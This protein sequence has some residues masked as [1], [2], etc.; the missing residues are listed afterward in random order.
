[1]KTGKHFEQTI[2]RRL[3]KEKDLLL[4]LSTGI[5]ISFIA[6]FLLNY[7]TISLASESKTMKKHNRLIQ[8]KSP[9]LLQHAENPVDWY[10]W[11]EEA[12]RKAKE[13]D[14][15]I[16]L[17]I[18]YSTCHWCHVMEK[19]SFEDAQV[20][21]LMN[22]AFVSI[23]VDREERPDIDNIYMTVCQMTSKGGCGW[24]LNIIMT[25]DKKPFF[26]ATYIPKETRFGRAGMLDLIPRIKEIWKI[27]R[28]EALSSANEITGALKQ[29]SSK[30]RSARNSTDLL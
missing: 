27:R 24:P 12:F 14:K 22:D 30:I 29:A 16:L 18:G 13:E 6:L 10:P 28:D 19:E 2:I 3:E 23:K 15:P 7:Q 20:A 11:G 4:I 25:P 9:Y 5:A 21:K 8:E 1:M 26:V 17:S